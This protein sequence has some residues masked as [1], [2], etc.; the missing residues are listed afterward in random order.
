MLPK[1]SEDCSQ[2][3]WLCEVYGWV[4]VCTAFLGRDDISVGWSQ[5]YSTVQYSTVQYSGTYAV[6]L[7]HLGQWAAQ[8]AP[9]T[10]WALHLGGDGEVLGQ[11]VN[12]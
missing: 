9:G 2:C 12:T 3:W 11:G 8:W 6:H 7:V 4:S 5:V 1:V 10:S